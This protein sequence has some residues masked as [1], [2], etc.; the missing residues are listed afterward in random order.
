MQG[1]HWPFTAL[2]CLC[3]PRVRASMARKM[4]A[5]TVAMT[6]C[7]VIFP[8]CAAAV[9]GPA[10]RYLVLGTWYGSCVHGAG[11]SV[12]CMHAFLSLAF[13]RSSMLTHPMLH[14][15]RRRYGQATPEFV[16]AGVAAGFNA[17]RSVDS[18][19]YSWLMCCTLPR[20]NLN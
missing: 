2:G 16:S 9:D 18:Q 3:W 17:V 19:R 15:V 1:H 10:P 7:S 12:W 14:T 13:D 8:T 11:K 6:I 5:T 4:M 20:T